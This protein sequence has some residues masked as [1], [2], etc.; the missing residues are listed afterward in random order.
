MTEEPTES[1][2]V[3]EAALERRAASHPLELPRLIGGVL[4]DIRA[5]AEGMAVLPKLLT[6]LQGIEGRVDTLNAEVS[7][8]RAGVE[9][10][11]GDVGEMKESIARVE[12]QL[13]DVNRVVHP[14][15]RINQRTR[16]RPPDAGS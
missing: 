6:T 10:M 3:P 2:T 15:R 11:S 8:M 9:A 13:E 5:I 7:R 1:R 12:P 4:G 14:L 16:R